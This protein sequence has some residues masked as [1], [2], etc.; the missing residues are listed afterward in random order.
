MPNLQQ[1]NLGLSPIHRRRR[2][3]FRRR[4]L[5]DHAELSRLLRDHVP[6]A[7][8]VALHAQHRQCGGGRRLGAE[9][10]N[11]AAYGR[12]GTYTSCKRKTK[13]GDKKAK[14]DA[15]KKI[16]KKKNKVMMD[17]ADDSLNIAKT[18]AGKYC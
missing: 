5:A 14:K 8:V 6:Y 16:E 2:V 11:F 9:G 4:E 18:P 13:K 17:D 12:G 3:L 7:P 15:M 10:I 1:S